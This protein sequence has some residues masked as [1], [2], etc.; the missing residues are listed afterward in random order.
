MD[1]HGRFAIVT[2]AE[3]LVAA[4]N[5]KD[6]FRDRNF[7]NLPNGLPVIDMLSS[8]FP[9]REFS[10]SPYEM[11]FAPSPFRDLNDNPFEA[12]EI[13]KVLRPSDVD[14][15][16]LP[17]RLWEIP[18]A[19]HI[20]RRM[21]W[22]ANRDLVTTDSFEVPTTY[23][24]VIAKL[25]ARLRSE[26]GLKQLIAQR[27]IAPEMLKGLKFDV[28]RPFGNGY[29]DNGDGVVD[30]PDE[31]TSEVNIDQGGIAMDLNNDGVTNN[32]TDAD[33]RLDFARQLYVLMLLVCDRV[34]VDLDGDGMPD[35]FGFESAMAQW[36]I[37]VVD[38]R[39]S[40]SIMTRFD[41]DPNP[42]DVAGWNPT[43]NDFVF[44]CERPELLLTET[45]AAH[46]RRT[47]DLDTDL[48]GDDTLDGD[49]D[50]DQR[51]RPEAF[52]FFELTNPW[53]QNS[54]NQQLDAS[55]YD[56]A[57]QGVD[58]ARLSLPANGPES[59]VWRISVER[60]DRGAAQPN[61]NTLPRRYVYF[62]DPD[63]S[64]SDT[65]G[66]D[67]DLNVEV[68][69]TSFGQDRW[70]PVV[71]RWWEVWALRIRIPRANFAPTLVV[72]TERRRRTNWRTRWNS[73]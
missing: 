28:N 52:A 72:A 23:D 12:L 63:A 43:G 37:N 36:A 55:L 4:G 62:T 39:D 8:T 34:D 21:F 20:A 59:P 18:G 1:L 70:L 5:S 29:D 26:A 47:E 16:L 42:W 3:A 66:D 51:L 38:F 54:L 58:L 48:S 11:S 19:D 53:T 27:A 15:N 69:F 24:S 60:P 13:E 35:P 32:L 25:F 71:K 17:A 68:F 46:V 33:A 65:V 45:F 67:D 10:I 61:Q 7:A 30:N 73:I 44:G 22:A 2:P 50:F 6:D 14:S 57:T 40:D 64:G 49:E 9:G 41:Y 56:A 31:A